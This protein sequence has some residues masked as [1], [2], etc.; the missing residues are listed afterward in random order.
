ML[1]KKK[2]SGLFC[3]SFDAVP[4]SGVIVEFLKIAEIF[5]KNDY[6]IYLDL[7]YEVKS[8]K[9]NFFKDYTHEKNIFPSWIHLV[10][11]LD[12]PYKSY[13]ENLVEKILGYVVK[14]STEIKQYAQLI[15]DYSDF[16]ANKLIRLWHKLN[17][18]LVIVENG[19]LPENII[20]TKALYK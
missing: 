18:K 20:F 1:T 15:D 19:T 2:K 3:I 7:G 16:I 17:I 11:T 10:K 5:H 6:S 8:D 9:K 12:Q 14:D 4:L 13:S